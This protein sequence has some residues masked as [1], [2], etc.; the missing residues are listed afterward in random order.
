MTTRIGVGVLGG[1]D[2]DVSYHHHQPLLQQQCW[3]WGPSSFGVVVVVFSWWCCWL[4]R[5][6]GVLLYGGGASSSVFWLAS[7]SAGA[8]L[9]CLPLGA[10]DERTN[11]R[12]NK[13]IQQRLTEGQ[14][15]GPGR[16]C[17][18]DTAR[19]QGG[20]GREGGREKGSDVLYDMAVQ[21]QVCCW[22]GKV[23][24]IMLHVYIMIRRAGTFRPVISS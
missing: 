10:R 13:T 21:K 17:Q 12:T 4:C 24:P 19:L 18:S 20:V 7:W 9:R 14:G 22:S 3:W 5:G 23:A 6:G 16:D 15:G 2:G 1:A 8:G 11:E